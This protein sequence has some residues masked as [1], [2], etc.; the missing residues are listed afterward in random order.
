MTKLILLDVDGVLVDPGGYRAALRATVNHF[1]KL[2]GLPDFDITEEK[3]S[4]L[5][6]H[7][8]FSE[9]D[10]VPVLLASLLSDILARHPQP[11]L[12]A[13]PAS[14][15]T[16]IESHLNGYRPTEIIIP[17]FELIAG[18]YPAEAA[19]QSGRF[20][21]IPL[22]LRK[23]LLSGSRDVNLSHTTRLFQHYSLGSQR[24]SE[25][26]QL[27]A[28]IETESLLSIHDR[29]NIDK[30]MQ[31]R[32]LKTGNHPVGFTARPSGPPREAGSHIGYAP[33]AEIALELVGLPDIPLIAFGRLEYLARHHSLET[34]GLVKPSPVHALAASIAAFSG[35]EW[36]GLQAAHHW[37]QTR[38]LDEVQNHLP[39]SFELIV[40]EDTMGGMN[41]VKAAGELFQQAGLD[42]NLKMF[43]LTSGSAAKTAA[44]E[45]AG[46]PHFKDWS[47]LME[48]AEF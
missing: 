46:I 44:F 16:A 7:G 3:L 9:W 37:Q 8:I 42:V 6:R 30:T 24:F 13:D 40:V 11:D 41:S 38:Q 14:A 10:M 31:A 36:L 35:D 18:Q 29:S 21:A 25:T 23:N 22:E 39:K 17:E 5:E 20:N 32:L 27:P 33:E 1:V 4:E 15:V 19:L 47:V 48:A 12:P 43:G 34:S 26:Y 2:M 45:K 28:E